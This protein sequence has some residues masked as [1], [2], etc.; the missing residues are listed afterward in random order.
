M[1]GLRAAQHRCQPLQSYASNVIERLLRRQRYARGLRVEAHQPGAF[2]LGAKAVFHQPIP[3][4]AGRAELGNFFKEV[5]VRVE[6]ITQPRAK[7]VHIEPAAASP[8]HVLNTVINGK[9]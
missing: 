6:E 5:A 4:L 3:D 8:R 2:L 9:S 7:V 1:E